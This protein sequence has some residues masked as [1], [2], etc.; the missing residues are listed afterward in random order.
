MKNTNLLL[1]LVLCVIVVVAPLPG[2]EHPTEI[3]QFLVASNL[4]RSPDGGT[5]KG[6]IVAKES[7][8]PLVG[9]NVIVVG[10][11]FGAASD[12]RGEFVIR[13]VPAGTYE[14]HASMLG[15][16]PDTRTITV[17]Y[18]DSITIHFQLAPRPVDL[19]TVE[20]IGSKPAVYYKIPGSGDVIDA[21]LISV[22]HPLG[23]NEVLRRIP[24]VH[25]RDEEGFSLR[26]NIGIRGLLPT[27]STKVLLLEDGVPLTQAPYSDP[28]SYYHPPMSR[29]E[30]VE[31]LKGSG[32]ILFGPQTIGGVINYITPQPPS[33]TEGSIRLI[34]G[35][36]N[37]M[38]GHF[39]I[40]SA[41]G[42]VSFL[43][44]VT[45]NQGS[46]AR[47]NTAT[48]LNDLNAKVVWKQNDRARLTFKVN[49]YQEITN[50]TYAGLTTIEFEENPFQN[51]FKDDRF[52]ITRYGSH[53]MYESYLGDGNAA[54]AINLYG[55]AFHRDWWRQ[56][57]N[58]GTN[59][60]APRDTVGTRTIL[61][62]TRNDGRNRDYKVWGIEPRLRLN[63]HLFG[64]LNELD[65]G[66]RAHYEIQD[67]K[68]IQGNTPTAR[69][70]KL[71]EDNLRKADAYAG[72]VQN[73]MFLGQ[74]WTLSTGLRVENVHYARTNRLNNASGE[75]SFTEFVPGAGVTYVHSP[76]FTMY[77]GVHRGFAPPRVEDV[78]SNADGSSIE[79]DAEKSWNVELGLRTQS[80]CGGLSLHAT[81]FHMDFQNQIIPHT[82]AGGVT[83]TLT[84][85][86]ETLHRGIEMKSI[87]NIGRLIDPSLN[88]FF[89]AA[90]TYVPT[91]KYA[92]ERL[93]VIDQKTKITGNRLPYAP[94]YL[95]TL[96]LG[97]SI[98]QRADIRLEMIHVSDQFADDLNTVAPTPNGRRGIIPAQTVWSVSANYT[99]PSPNMT[100]ILSVKNLFDKVYIVDRSRGILPGT[101]RMIQY[102]IDW[103]F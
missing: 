27:R 20:I 91:A 11:R 21:H 60:T 40:G 45:R 75:T 54:F 2:Q 83:A 8:L 46:L 69:E 35:N 71:L 6:K 18:Q 64:Y 4:L 7:H 31:V 76:A 34:A 103:N 49:L 80:A 101:P 3:S 26:P 87:F 36:R 15:Y 48:A 51:Q 55:Y 74:R 23:V 1:Q 5:I 95:A 28:A 32:Q 30:R 14:I 59:A 9:A 25:V 52:Y 43:A 29:F 53:I 81:L 84:N 77:F 66:A 98:P 33:E 82:L 92:S 70:G 13:F 56:G 37:F 63:H 42:P 99:L 61:H 22:T 96:S 50:N 94:E 72:F 57:N 93:S 44:D 16:E 58:G 97:Y 78:I 65:L 62:P 12:K 67:R 47:E 100:M 10:T 90:L 88:L 85:A 102:G 79:L 41:W 17:G 89:D 86:G 24:G 68:Q 19:P 38:F 73:R 39:T